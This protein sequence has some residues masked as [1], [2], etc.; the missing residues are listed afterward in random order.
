MA[1]R[2]FGYVTSPF[3]NVFSFSGSLPQGYEKAD[4]R[5]VMR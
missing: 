2:F 3:E 4:T 5:F 1:S